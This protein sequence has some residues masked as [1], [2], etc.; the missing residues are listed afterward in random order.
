MPSEPFWKFIESRWG[1]AVLGVFVLLLIP[2]ISAILPAEPPKE[3][4]EKPDRLTEENVVDYVSTNERAA[5][6]RSRD[7]PEGVDLHL[8]CPTALDRVAEEGYY[9]TVR[10][11]GSSPASDGSTFVE[12]R[13][14]YLVD[15]TST[16]RIQT[17]DGPYE[18]GAEATGT[19][20]LLNFGR[21]NYSTRIEVRPADGR[22]SSSVFDHTYHVTE[23]SGIGQ[24]PVVPPGRYVIVAT[25]GTGEQRAFDW[26]LTEEPAGPTVPAFY[27]TPDGEVV[28]RPLPEPSPD[29]KSMW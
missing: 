4:P 16:T 21:Q 9:L 24:S 27:V 11:W 18:A 3:Y 23:L 5:V 25:E 29:S 12:D 20:Y 6:Y 7:P 28:V 2:A 8:D 15:E 13:S 22:N 26:N 1:V 19:F 14:F 10:C 17:E